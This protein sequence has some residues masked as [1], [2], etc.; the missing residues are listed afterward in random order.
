MRPLL[1]LLLLSALLPGCGADEAAPAPAPISVSVAVALRESVVEPVFAT[2]TLEADKLTEIGP[3][4]S[5]TVDTVH[6]AVGSRVA[7]GDPL[8]TTRQ[9]DYV[10]RLRQAEQAAR[11]AR[12]QHAQAARD[13]ARALELHERGVLSEDHL[14]KARTA[15]EMGA[16]QAGAAEA[17][18]ALARQSL[19]DSVVRAPY[20]GVITKR[21]VDEGAMLSAQVTSAPVVQL[22][23]ADI[24]EAVLQLPETE[25][26]RVRPGTRAELHVD[27]LAGPLAA[28]VAVVNDRVDSASRSFEVRIRLAN[29]DLVLKPGVFV[30]AELMPEPREVISLE[31]RA[32]LGTEGARHVFVE[33]GGRAKQRPIEAHDL[34]AARLEVLSGL[35]AGER[36]LVGPNLGRVAEG[37]A[38]ALEVSR[39]DR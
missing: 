12:A 39:A 28:E 30:R 35:V 38:I 1:P 11:L 7:E 17:S 22:M 32:V 19:A 3:R 8:F 5:G 20:A 13:L 23:K 26:A 6:V 16:A 29:A 31:R 25:L 10:L 9:A 21:Y 33:Q 14:E 27:G 4:V 15:A 36:V 18:A 34:D 24:V 2:G 37:A